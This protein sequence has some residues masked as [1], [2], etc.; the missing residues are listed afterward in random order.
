VFEKGSSSAESAAT[1]M[2][3]QNDIQKFILA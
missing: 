2:V 1:V 3:I